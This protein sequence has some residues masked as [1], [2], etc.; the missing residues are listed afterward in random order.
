MGT[1]RVYNRYVSEYINDLEKFKKSFP[2]LNKSSNSDTFQL[3]T[4]EKRE[5]QLKKPPGKNI[6]LSTYF[7]S[8]PDPQR[9]FRVKPSDFNFLKAWY[10]SVV[11]KSLKAVVFIDFHDN[12]FINKYESE[13]IKFIYCTLG[14]LSLNDERYFIFEEYLNY[15]IRDLTQVCITDISDVIFNKD[16]FIFFK[17]RPWHTLFVG[18]N[19]TDK[20]MFSR[21]NLERMS[22]LSDAYGL[23]YPGN[24]YIMPVYNAG[25]IGGDKWVVAYLLKKMCIYFREYGSD[26]N[27]NMLILNMVLYSYF[28]PNVSTNLFNK[29]FFRSRK[30]RKVVILIQKIKMKLNN[31]T[32][33]QASSV[34]HLNDICGNSKTIFTSYPLHNEFK[35]FYSDS[36]EYILHK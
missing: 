22:Q 26:K 25:I 15:Y 30:S 16:P 10:L 1:I 17:D 31:T 13:N 34:Q 14:N 2:K 35:S 32:W 8:K 29:F 6:I 4:R 12:A 28:C 19:H 27:L 18:R 5:I 7:T 21:I 3:I 9:Q 23:A 20:I 36:R 11:K 33:N 24:F